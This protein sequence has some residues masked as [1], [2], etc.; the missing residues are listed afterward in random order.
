MLSST[1][2]QIEEVE[3][4]IANHR[5]QI[6]ELEDK[7]TLAEARRKALV[8]RDKIVF[9]HLEKATKHIKEALQLVKDEEPDALNYV[10]E[11]V[12]EE[13]DDA[14][15]AVVEGGSESPQTQEE[16]AV[17]DPED[18]TTLPQ[19]EEEQP[20]ALNVEAEEADLLFAD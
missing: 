4:T 15:A 14:I 12:R 2:K 13:V 7:I 16:Q 9:K 1:K 20:V 8:A 19:I 3:K 5:S 18:K 6:Q 11:S 17:S 10:I